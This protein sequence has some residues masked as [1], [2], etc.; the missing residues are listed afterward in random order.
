MRDGHVTGVQD[1]CSSDLAGRS[2]PDVHLR[3]GLLA[4]AAPALRRTQRALSALS[5]AAEVQIINSHDR[6]LW[7]A[8]RRSEERRV[9]KGVG[10]VGGVSASQAMSN[11]Y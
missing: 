1:V 11:E 2:R 9:G 5:G 10:R 4:H 6:G 8:S 3:Q 7:E